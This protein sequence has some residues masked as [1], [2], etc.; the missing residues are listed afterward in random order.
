MSP[1]PRLYPQ[2]TGITPQMIYHSEIWKIIFNNLIGFAMLF[3]F[4][5]EGGDMVIWVANICVLIKITKDSGSFVLV[6]GMDT[7]GGTSDEALESAAE[8]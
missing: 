6:Y 1:S 3:C 2:L 7:Y 8:I 4:L 5:G